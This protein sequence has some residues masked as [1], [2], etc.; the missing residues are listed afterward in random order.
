LIEKREIDLD[1]KMKNRKRN[2]IT[3]KII[4]NT[5]R[6]TSRPIGELP[7]TVLQHLDGLEDV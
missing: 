1:T 6:P 3:L 5:T 4:F 7:D 2:M